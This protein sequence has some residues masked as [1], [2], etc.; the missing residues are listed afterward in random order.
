VDS[1]AAAESLVGAWIDDVIPDQPALLARQ[2]H[3]ENHLGSKHD[4]HGS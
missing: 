3:R 1:I 2:E 4:H